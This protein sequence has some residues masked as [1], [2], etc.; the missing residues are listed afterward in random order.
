MDHAWLPRARIGEFVELAKAI[1]PARYPSLASPDYTSI[2]DAR[3]FERLLNALDDA[4]Q[5]GATVLPLLPGPAFD[6]ASRKIAPHIVLNAPADSLLMQREIFGP[7]LPLLPYDLLNDVVRQ[8]N[9]GPRPL[10][11]YPFSHD[12]AQ[13]QMLLDRVMSGGVSVNDALFHV[14][15]HDLPF[16]G[17]GDSGMGHY[18]GYEGFVAFSKL[19]PVFYLSLIH[20]CAGPGRPVGQPGHAGGAPGGRWPGRAG[21]G[22]ALCL[23]ARLAAGARPAGAGR[24][25][26][27]GRDA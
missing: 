15:Q 19:R 9:V 12:A 6:A 14:G 17:V 3:S 24:H 4:R 18:H 25:D 16:G 8:V 26:R 7:I 13:V 23:A 2:I 21:H 27:R 5:R 1:V 11:I 10:A 22:S 20:I